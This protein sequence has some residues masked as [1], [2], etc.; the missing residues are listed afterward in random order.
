M[1]VDVNLANSQANQLRNC[2]TQLNDL[3]ANLNSYKASLDASW[4]SGEIKK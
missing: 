4:R 2:A 3:I 1:A